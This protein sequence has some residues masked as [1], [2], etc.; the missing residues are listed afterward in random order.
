[1]VIDQE[2]GAGPSLRRSPRP[3]PWTHSFGPS[4]NI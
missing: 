3:S 2:H 4:T 1:V